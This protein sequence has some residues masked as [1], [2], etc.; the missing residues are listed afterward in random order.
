MSALSR[1]LR[2]FWR[3]DGGGAML[4]AP[5]ILPVFLLAMFGTMEFGRA[6]F[7]YNFCSYAA[8]LGARYASVHG[9][10]SGR[11]LTNSTLTTLVDGW[12]VGLTAADITTALTWSPDAKP[13]STVTVQVNY[14]YRP[15]FASYIM[16][17]PVN[18]SSTSKSAI[19]Q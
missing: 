9:L 14:T 13:G 15:M 18:L 5:L 12:A 11:Q 16:H 2:A 4:E 8:R 10:Q 17:G 1:L 19:F 3:N 6:V 7:A